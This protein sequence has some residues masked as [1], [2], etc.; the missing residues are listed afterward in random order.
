MFLRDLTI[1]KQAHCMVAAPPNKH[2]ALHKVKRQLLRGLLFYGVGGIKNVKVHLLQRPCRDFLFS[3][4][5]SSTRRRSFCTVP[6]PRIT[7]AQQRT[8]DIR[9]EN[10]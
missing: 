9:L 3:R 7:Q 5:K 8:P 10:A 1:F 6:V 4:R 2:S